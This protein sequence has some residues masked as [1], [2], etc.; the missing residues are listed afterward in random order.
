MPKEL[1]NMKNNDCINSFLSIYISS[2]IKVE[3]IYKLKRIYNFSEF[4][5]DALNIY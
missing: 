3:L 5:P 2:S 4:Y 1:V